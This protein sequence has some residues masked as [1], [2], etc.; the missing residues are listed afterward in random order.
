[1]GLCPV[2]LYTKKSLETKEGGRGESNPIGYLPAFDCVP[3]MGRR[4]APCTT[5][6]SSLSPLQNK[7]GSSRARKKSC[8]CSSE[9]DAG[10][11][12]PSTALN[13]HG[14]HDWMQ[15]CTVHHVR[16]HVLPHAPLLNKMG[17]CPVGPCSKK[18]WRQ[19]KA[20]AAATAIQATVY[21]A[22][23]PTSAFVPCI[24]GQIYPTFLCGFE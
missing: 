19:R 12:T 23:C 22:R 13:Y 14:L 2:G 17:L 18:V 16:V 15:R 10:S 21:C 7:R 5:S 24:H 11:R 8:N 1:M 6:A 9:A 4:C 20:D 3:F